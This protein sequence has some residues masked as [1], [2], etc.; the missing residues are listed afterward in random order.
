M[1]LSKVHRAVITDADVDYVGSLTMPPEVVEAAG[2][3]QHEQIMVADITTGARFWTYVMV[4]EEAG[5]F[6]LNGAAAKLGAPGDIVIIFTFAWMDEAEAKPHVPRVVH[7]D[8]KNAIVRVEGPA[9]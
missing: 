5:K 2:F 4:G 3:L 8:E 1:L 9:R 7:M 6:C